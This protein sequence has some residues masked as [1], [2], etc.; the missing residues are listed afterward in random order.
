MSTSSAGIRHELLFG[1]R[2]VRCFEHRAASLWDMFE[3]TAR[4]VADSDALLWEPDGRATYSELE[5]QA[6]AL[7]SRLQELGMRSGER[8]ATF[9]SNR[10]EYIVAALAVWRMGAVLVPIDVRLNTGE[11]AQILR[12]CG[13]RI[14]FCEHTLRQTLPALETLPDLDRFIV[15]DGENSGSKWLE[16][17]SLLERGITEPAATVDEEDA[18]AILYTS[19]TTGEPKGVVIAHV[20]AIHST[21]HFQHVWRLPAQTRSALAIPGTNVTGLVTIILTMLSLGGCIVLMPPFKAGE[22]LRIAALRRI[23]HTFMVPAQYQLCLMQ[24]DLEEYD[25]SAWKLGSTGGAPM[26]AVVIREL[27]R[28]IPSLQISDGYG[29]TELAS[30]AIIRPP[31]LTNEH[32]DSIGVPVACADVVIMT[33]SGDEAPP[34]VPGELWIKGPMVSCGYWRNP[35]ATNDAFVDGYWKSG[36]IASVDAHGL[37]RLHDRKRDVVNRGGYKVYSVE[38]EGILLEHPLV[39]EAAVIARPDDV[40]G[41]RVH[42]VVFADG[43]VDPNALKRLCAERLADY[44]VPE[45]FTILCT[46]LPRNSSGKIVKRALR[47]QIFSAPYPPS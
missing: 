4:R 33:E 14:L 22:F 13:A 44:K 21:L 11:V 17:H 9:L 27:Q 5:T 25:L 36:D 39:Y 43:D 15:V 18:A 32:P 38:V 12:H 35:N 30:P 7:G 8:V 10:R 34:G 37:Y 16:F 2:V 47:D 46:P 42:A 20:N 29:A 23:H 31:D 24:D 1:Q 26:P 28:R 40:L 6:A 3:R 41:E 19:G 45:T